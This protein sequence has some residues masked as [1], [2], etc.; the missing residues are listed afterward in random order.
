MNRIPAS[1]I[2]RIAE[3][4]L[5][6]EEKLERVEAEKARLRRRRALVR[7]FK[8]LISWRPL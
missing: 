6:R 2:R 5:E 4:E 7:W 3:I 8:R 1:T